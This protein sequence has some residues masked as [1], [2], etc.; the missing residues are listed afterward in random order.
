MKPI[1]KYAT[2]EWMASN[3]LANNGDIKECQRRTKAWN[4]AS[5]IAAGL[6]LSI[7]KVFKAA[8]GLH[9]A[10]I[11]G[12]TTLRTKYDSLELVLEYCE[13][14]ADSPRVKPCSVAVPIFTCGTI[15]GIWHA[16]VIFQ[17]GGD[18]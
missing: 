15:T 7:R 6:P 8:T 10:I 4:T 18:K 16:V 12:S 11:S 1:P 13:H 14:L 2:K 17:T 3:V 9:A 5:V